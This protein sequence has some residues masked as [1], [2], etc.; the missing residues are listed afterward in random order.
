MATDDSHPDAE[1]HVQRKALLWELYGLAIVLSAGCLIL[2]GLYLLVQWHLADI[3]AKRSEDN[4]KRNAPV[5]VA[6]VKVKH[7][8]ITDTIHLPGRFEAW[9]AVEVPAEAA[10][11]IIPTDTTP[12]VDGA[13]VKKGQPLLHIDAT[14]YEIAA[15]SAKAALQ[16]AQ[17]NHE[18][19]GKLVTEGVK[20]SS[21][22]EKEANALKQAQAASEA[23][24]LALE[25][26][27][28]RSPIKGVVDDLLPEAGEYVHSGDKIASVLAFDRVRVDIGI[29]EK[30]VD[31]VRA[32][33]EKNRNVELQ[34]DA[35]RSGNGPLLVEGTC[36]HL[37]YQPIAEA[38]VYL[39]QLEVSNPEHRLR[40]GMFCEARIVRDVRTNAI[41]IPLSSVLTQTDASSGKNTYH[42]YVAEEPDAERPV[43]TS[44][45]NPKS[46]AAP[47]LPALVS[48]WRTVT[49]GILMGRNVEITSGLKPGDRLIVRGQ[50]SVAHNSPVMI[51]QSID[52]PSELRR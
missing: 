26:C 45:A 12:V 6:V 32:Y 46:P 38:Y 11:Q 33:I 37:S 27:V 48:K 23:A 43:A 34:V 18:R 52:D 16:L 44:P 19:T 8:T 28:V 49:C 41:S 51:T 25:R 4:G 22:L 5:P 2:G 50:R 30:D 20:S 29:P 40:P 1:E 17:Q 14:D 31:Q 3:K 47:L 21:A 7:Q 10:G 13:Q 15:R 42:V 24:D 39:M 9:V 36:L 35:I